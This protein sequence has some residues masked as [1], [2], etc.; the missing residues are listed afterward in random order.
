MPLDFL[1][2]TESFFGKII[3]KYYVYFIFYFNFIFPIDLTVLLG[4][5]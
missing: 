3:I 2:L 1:A 4:L 5:L